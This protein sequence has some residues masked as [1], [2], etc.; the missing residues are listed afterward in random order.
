MGKEPAWKSLVSLL[1]CW[2]TVLPVRRFTGFAKYHTQC[3]QNQQYPTHSVHFQRAARFTAF[4]GLH[5]CAGL[6]PCYVLG[7]VAVV[8]WGAMQRYTL[9]TQKNWGRPLGACARGQVRYA[10]L[11]LYCCDT[12]VILLWYC[13]CTAVVL[14]LDCMWCCCGTACVLLW[15]CRVSILT[16]SRPCLWGR[17]VGMQWLLLRT[18]PVGG[19]RDCHM[20]QHTMCE[21]HHTIIVCVRCITQRSEVH[22]S[23]VK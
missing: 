17:L 23:G 12:A 5:A 21:V 14:P 8:P 10:G 6:M 22:V 7:W 9:T 11:F 2:Q 20:M 15:Y 3:C 18:T 19:S 1:R 13:F 4:H 16:R